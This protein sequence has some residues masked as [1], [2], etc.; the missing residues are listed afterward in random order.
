MNYNL[1]CPICN[2][3][4]KDFNNKIE[5]NH[6]AI[7]YCKC[8]SNGCY[9]ICSGIYIYVRHDFLKLELCYKD[10]AYIIKDDNNF[11]VKHLVNYD[12]ILDLDLDLDFK[13][14]EFIENIPD[15]LNNIDYFYCIANKIEKNM[16]FL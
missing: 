2:T 14:I 16:V 15:L 6:S 8:T 13:I 4:L 10:I 3:N 9:S 1:T 7:F 5:I 12:S 11:I